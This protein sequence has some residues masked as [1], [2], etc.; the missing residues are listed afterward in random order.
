MPVSPS[1]CSVVRFMP[2]LAAAPAAPPTTGG[3]PEGL[4][5]MLALRASVDTP[6]VGVGVKRRCFNSDSGTAS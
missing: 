2:S 5:N 1:D 3:L 6:G 4:T